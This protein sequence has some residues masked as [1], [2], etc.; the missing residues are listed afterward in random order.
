MKNKKK[1]LTSV[2][3]ALALLAVGF[4]LYATNMGAS[5]LSSRLM[6]QIESAKGNKIEERLVAYI[7]RYYAVDNPKTTS[8]EFGYDSIKPTK[9]KGYGAVELQNAS[10][11][12]INTEGNKQR[13]IVVP[14][15]IIGIKERN[16][17]EYMYLTEGDIEFYSN[18]NADAQKEKLFLVKYE[19]NQGQITLQD[20]HVTSSKIIGKNYQ[21][22]DAKGGSTIF[23]IGSVN[24]SSSQTQTDKGI[25]AKGS[26]NY[27]D[28]MPGQIMQM[29]MG[30]ISPMNINVKYDYKGDDFYNYLEG[31]TKT[32]N[33]ALNVEDFSLKVANTGFVAN[34]NLK[35]TLNQ[36]TK[37]PNGAVNFRVPNYAKMFEFVGNYF[38]L[39]VHE[40][41]SIE[42]MLTEM[43]AIKLASAARQ[44]QK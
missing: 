17:N 26:A 38:P 41:P 31:K 32:L 4:Y 11:L 3:T 18:N 44:M 14:K 22:Q 15:L 33:G 13:Q 29:I 37:Y 39:I 9:I 23:S 30:N 7:G 5:A 40:K 27:T 10:L 42:A 6:Q 36:K 21:L 43:H 25:E 12:F 35:F 20:G 8:I 19:E 28:I 34:T 16:T 2:L 1:L 24:V